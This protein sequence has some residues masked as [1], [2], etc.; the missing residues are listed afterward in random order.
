MRIA[1]AFCVVGA[2]LHLGSRLAAAEPE[3]PRSP[4]TTWLAEELDY[5]MANLAMP[6]GTRPY[7]LAYTVTERQVA[8]LE[9][10][11]G[12]PMRDQDF[13]RR[14]LQV[15]ARV[16]GYELDSTHQIRGG[17]AG[18]DLS[19][20][21]F[22]GAVEVSLADN[23][24]ALQQAVWRATDRAFKSAAKRYQRVL[25]NRK[26][27]VDEEDQSGDF[28]REPPAVH[29]DPP[30]PLAFDRAT[31]RQR[32]DRVSALARR[33]PLLYRSS[34]ML[35]GGAEHRWMV[36]TEGTR[37]ETGRQ[38]WRVILSAG[39][40]A[41]DG[42]ELDQSFTFDAANEAG[43]PDEAAMIQ[44]FERTIS[45]VL[46]L[47]AAPLIEPFTGPAIL[48][49]RAS[50]VFFHEIFGHRI[51]GHRQKD[52]EEGQTFARKVNQPV[53]P[54]FLSVRDDPTLATFRGQDLR[55]FY[56]FD[57]E[58]VPAQNTV[59]VENGTLRTFL[60]SRSPLEGFPRSNG[61]GRREPGRDVVSRMG[62]LIIESGN[63]VPF[64]ELRRQLL[65][66]C[67]RQDKPYGLLFEDIAG[68]FT[69][70]SRMGAQSFKVLPV[71]VYRV[72]ADGRPD[73]LVRGVD[74]V[75]TPLTSFSKILA[76]GDDPAVFNGTCG[77]E[78]GSVPVSAISPSILVAQ[79]E[80]EKR[81]REQDRPP[82]LPSPL[83]PAV[84][85][86]SSE[87]GILFQA[88]SDELARAMTLEMPGLD[89]PYFIQYRVEDSLAHTLSAADG[90]LLSSQRTR[91]R[92]LRTQ[93]RVGSF[94]LDNTNFADGG[95]GF[96]NPIEQSSLPLTD[97]Y[98]ALRQALWLAT[99]RD[100]K[101]AVETL[102]RKR[103]YLR[104]KHIVDRPADF[105][106]ATPLVQSGPTARLEFDEPAWRNRLSEL[107]AQFLR[108]PEIL[109]SG[110]QLV[111]GAQDLYLVNSEGTRLRLP[112]N[113][114]V[115]AFSA[116][117][118]APD[119]MRLSDGR[120]YAGRT[121]ADLPALPALIQDLE[122]LVA[123][124]RQRR[125]AEVLERYAGPVLFDALA[126]PQLFYSLL[127]EGFAGRPEAV[128]ETRRRPGT[129]NLEA[130]LGTRLLPTSFRVWDDPTQV[131]FQ[132]QTLLGHY[133]HDDEAVPAAALDLV[134]D[135]RLTALCRSRA[136]LRP[137]SGSTGHARSPAN[138]APQAH[139]ANLF[140]E[141]QKGLSP[142]DL[143][144]E[145]L[146]AARDEG[147][148]FALRVTALQ[149]PG[150]FSSRPDLIRYFNRA[151]AGEPGRLGDPV[152]VYKVSVKD[153]QET[154]LRGLE[155]APVELRAL[156]HIL[157]AGLEPRV[158][159]HVGIGYFGVTPPVAVIAPPVLFEDLELQRI[160]EEFEALPLL[161]PPRA[162]R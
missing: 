135:G 44:A 116:Q 24:D 17:D 37:L 52:V 123:E 162:R 23:R 3:T 126:G 103:A 14:F 79:I 132:G 70:T 147:L 114:A 60:L 19:E 89:R 156:R 54:D 143:K 42:M 16:G 41:E 29:R 67:R 6:D 88:L 105:S 48:R 159:N 113:G 160:R 4:L 158:F 56:A 100:Y 35:T 107:S 2:A 31:W 73:E 130:R 125:E 139:V 93:V 83:D 94:E 120:F 86:V 131:T 104:D 9:A 62:N 72:F 34:V 13:H 95:F 98:R 27:Q 28:T 134:K 22:A 45:Q 77:A 38:L 43:L 81:R 84:A 58:G 154:P 32:L 124:L 69:G 55:G 149:V 57:D 150:A 51:E 5:A 50:G 66:E 153:G 97:D 111:A 59:L 106:A 49:N 136:P 122:A 142:E 33:H 133:L 144:A 119:G 25:T 110:V 21:M 138:S 47:R 71:V 65:E 68:G 92:E 78:S 118:Q 137:L 46:A 7:Y 101:N 40:K 140:I 76:A 87:G 74:I 18:F 1:L 115:L 109:E 20:R 148:E 12:A 112:D 10:V 96:G 102:T 121:V 11:C 151:G 8:T 146:A 63:Q 141:D 129:L 82:L 64:A 91:Q 26:T 127:G 99:D 157:A 85:E 53:L 155:F 80:V 90:A 36:T 30:V 39:T 108:F 128:G 152:A 161:P 145:L 61:H 75:G 15:D 117:V